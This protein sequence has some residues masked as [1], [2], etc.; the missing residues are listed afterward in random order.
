MAEAITPLPHYLRGAHDR[1][2][3]GC[4]A[5]ARARPPVHP[6]GS[7]ESLDVSRRSSTALSDVVR[8]AAQH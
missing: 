7:L 4:V 3:D 2:R 1:R 8:I 6:A 5:L